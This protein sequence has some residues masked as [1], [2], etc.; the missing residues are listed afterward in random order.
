[1][2]E[3]EKERALHL[4]LSIFVC[5]YPNVVLLMFIHAVLH[6]AYFYLT[7][8]GMDNVHLSFTLCNLPNQ[9]LTLT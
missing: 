9:T 6:S 1:M 5:L 7:F 4:C 8:V 2:K 3:I